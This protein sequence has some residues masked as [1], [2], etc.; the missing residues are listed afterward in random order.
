MPFVISRE[1]YL[2]K[3]K[4]NYKYMTKKYYLIFFLFE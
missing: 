1:I 3:W 4:H 2:R